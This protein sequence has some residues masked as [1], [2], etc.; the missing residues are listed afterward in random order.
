MCVC[1]AASYANIQ[2]SRRLFVAWMLSPLHGATSDCFCTLLGTHPPISDATGIYRL[3]LADP[4]LQQ[5]SHHISHSI[6][7]I[8]PQCSAAARR[9]R[10]GQQTKSTHSFIF[11]PVFLVTTF[12]SCMPFLPTPFVATARR[13][14]VMHLPHLAWMLAADGPLCRRPN[15]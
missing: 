5:A 10:Y 6:R 1:S 15:G 11:I 14:I 9:P 13:L 4:P 8:A 12:A 2:P 7:G 3:A